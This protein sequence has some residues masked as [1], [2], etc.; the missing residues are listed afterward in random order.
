MGVS[1]MPSVAESCDQL[2]VDEVVSKPHLGRPTHAACHSNFKLRGGSARP[3]WP[4]YE[5]MKQ[6]LTSHLVVQALPVNSVENHFLAMN[7]SYRV[8]DPSTEERGAA[9]SPL[10]FS[11]SWRFIERRILRGRP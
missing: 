9:K 10:L 3:R 1:P 6:P 11:A 5:V 2:P 4:W 7:N 8:D